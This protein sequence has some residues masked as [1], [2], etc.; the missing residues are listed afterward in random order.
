MSLQQYL[1]RYAESEVRLAAAVPGQWQQALVIPAYRES[2]EFLHHRHPRDNLLI[3]VLNRPP[4]DGDTAW[5]NT[6]ITSLPHPVWRNAQ[7]SLHNRADNCAV[8]VVDRCLDGEPIPEK[9]GVGLARKIG[10]DIAC[11]LLATNKLAHPWLGC[12]DADALLPRNYWDALKAQ[13]NTAAACV[14]PFRHLRDTATE[15]AIAQYELHML[16]YV[17]GLRFADSAYAWPTIGSCIA[18]DALAY[19]QVRGY[20]KKAGGEDFY[21]LNKLAKIGG[22]RHASQP[23]IRLSA[24][25]SGRVPF[26]TGPALR[27]IL[28]LESTASYRSYHP[29]SFTYLKAILI[30]LNQATHTNTGVSLA[31]IAAAQELVAER[32]IEL[33]N[34]FRCDIAVAQTLGN[35]R[36]T[37]QAQRHIQTWFDGFRSL[38]LIHAC[39]RWLPDRPLNE[40]LRN[41]HW[42]APTLTDKLDIG[43]YFKALQQ[44]L[45]DEVIRGP[46]LIQTNEAIAPDSINISGH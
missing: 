44:S 24:R 32:L 2:P 29:D 9:Q 18:F 31:E 41:A 40:C 17:A 39:R 45:A 11:Q 4:N 13:T 46:G 7:L 34:E 22:I 3:A 20:P 25:L 35:S 10:A 33:W 14:F 15:S 12:T 37:H 43:Q 23:E 38:K 26:G 30:G 42:L 5:A 8:L 28:A 21:L 19:A 27:K 1:E 6:I 36:S 16:Y